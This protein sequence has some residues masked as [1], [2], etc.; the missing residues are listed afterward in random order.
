MAKAPVV[1]EVQA[2]SNVDSSYWYDWGLHGSYPSKSYESFGAKSPLFNIVRDDDRCGDGLLFMEP[3]GGYVETPGPVVVDARGELVWTETRWGQ[4][5][6]VKVQ[7]YKGKDY[8]TFWIGEDV[9]TFAG[10]TG[11]YLM[12]GSTCPDPPMCLTAVCDMNQHA[13]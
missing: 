5:M 10:G 7:S 4:A 13:Y 8:I 2:A 6:D 12:V 3:R 11:T 9:G 1:D